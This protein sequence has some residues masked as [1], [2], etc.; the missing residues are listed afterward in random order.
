VAAVWQH[1]KR[2]EVPASFMQ[3]HACYRTVLAA[4]LIVL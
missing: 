3:A 2:K 4:R 1:T